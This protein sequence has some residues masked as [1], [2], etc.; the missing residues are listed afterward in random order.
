MIQ[1]NTSNEERNQIIY[2]FLKVK[3]SKS[4]NFLIEKIRNII[5]KSGISPNQV[6]EVYQHIKEKCKSLNILG[7]MTI[8]SYEQSTS[9]AENVD[10]IV[11]LVYYLFGFYGHLINRFFEKEPCKLQK[12]ASRALKH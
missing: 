9:A 10:F 7:L 2:I 1:V 3:K 11:R 5:E 12:R 4:V 8:G 6:I